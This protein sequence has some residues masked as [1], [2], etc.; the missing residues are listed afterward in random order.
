MM[1]LVAVNNTGRNILHAV[2]HLIT[3]N[4]VALFIQAC[5]APHNEQ[6]E[7]RYNI[8]IKFVFAA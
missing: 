7:S 2:A 1:Q 8:K 3:G 4:A 5:T 6:S